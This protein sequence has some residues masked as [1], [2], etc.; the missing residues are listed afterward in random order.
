MKGIALLAVVLAFAPSAFAEPRADRTSIFSPTELALEHPKEY[1]GLSLPQ[2]QDTIYYDDGYG[3]WYSTVGVEWGVRF[4]THL[5]C[6]LHSILTMTFGFGEYCSLYVR[7]DSAGR[8]GAIVRDTTYLGGAYPGWDRIDLGS[9]YYE[10]NSFWITGRYQ[11][12]PYIIADSA[13]D[14]RRSCYSFDGENW[15]PYSSGDLMIR[16]VVA[17][18][19]TLAH[20]VAAFNVTGLPGGVVAGSSYTDTVYFANYG[21]AVE[22]FTLD[23]WV[24]DSAGVVEL[25]TLLTVD[26]L[27]PRAFSKGSSSWMPAIYG[28]TYTVGAAVLLPG[29]LNPGNDTS[30]LTVYSYMEGEVFYDDFSSEVWLNVNRDDNDKFAV[31]YELEDTPCYVTGARFLVNDTLPF[32]SLTLCPDTAGF[33]DT[34]NAYTQVSAV[35]SSVP[36]SWV[37]TSFDTSLTRVDADTV[38]LV[39]IWPSSRMGPYVGSDADHPVDGHSWAYSDSTGWVTWTESDFMMRVICTPATGVAEEGRVAG[40]AGSWLR[41]RPNPFAGV[42]K[43]TL[44]GISA[45]R[46]VKGEKVS[47]CAF[48]L[49]GRCV[50]VF[51]SSEV[52]GLIGGAGLSWDGTD[53]EGKPLPP[54][55]YFLVFRSGDSKV[56]EKAVLIR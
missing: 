15:L 56:T 49:A 1:R 30:L 35:S 12:P 3:F 45:S 26:S 54:A 11:K 55:I 53:A 32:E 28:E 46:N 8:P 16:A 23:L 44:G 5:P 25:D 27:P 43:L 20:D 24:T 33:P 47:L 2:G 52:E 18:G 10:M 50:R 29:D 13:N 40:Y 38:W 6:T 4:S 9:P 34:S 17:Y 36:G 7:E 31:M 48:D 42:T 21:T 19:E 14:G 37:W 22:S 51:S 41:A 39:L